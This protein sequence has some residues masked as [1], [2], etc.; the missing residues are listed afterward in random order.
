MT[1]IEDFY[2]ERFLWKSGSP[3]SIYSRS[4]EQWYKGKISSVFIDKHTHKEWF[5]VRYNSN[6]KKYIQRLCS[7]I[8]PLRTNLIN[9]VWII[10]KNQY[11]E[12]GQTLRRRNTITH[13]NNNTTAIY[14]DDTGD[15]CKSLTLCKWSLN[16]TI[17]K[18]IFS[19]SRGFGFN[20]YSIA[21]YYDELIVFGFIQSIQSLLHKYKIYIP[22]R[23]Y[24]RILLY[25]GQT[26][27]HYYS[28]GNNDFGELGIGHNN[29]VLQ[30]AHIDER[31]PEL[32]KRGII[33]IISG[34]AA[35]NI[36]WITNNCSL[37][38]HGQNLQKYANKKTDEEYDNDEK[39]L[40][41]E[42]NEER[43]SMPTECI[44]FADKKLKCISG[45]SSYFHCMVVTDDGSVWSLGKGNYGELGHG[46]NQHLFTDNFVKIKSLNKYN[47]INVSCGSYF[48]LFLSDEGDVWSCGSNKY[49]QCGLGDNIQDKHRL[50]ERIDYFIDEDI[51]VKEIQ[52]G[53]Y[54]SIALDID[55]YAYCWGR[56]NIGQ[57]ARII[58]NKKDKIINIPKL[59]KHLMEYEIIKIK[60]GCN[61]SLAITENK[62]YYMWGCNDFNECCYDANANDNANNNNN[63]YDDV[64]GILFKPN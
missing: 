56:N 35:R 8:K 58:K 48:S 50:P 2:D 1:S 46:G 31:Q 9:T 45:S 32:F 53:L 10:G 59:L 27:N 16:D 47:I 5:I 49:G 7:H 12:C 28:I 23:I 57:C 43:N 13:N 20:I 61:H 38:I 52:C 37:Y 22:N 11:N 63:K 64:N 55:G 15:Y 4:N 14:D 18:N 36:C 29:K 33:R 60:V 44:F 41:N 42:E 24:L 6:Q 26:Y 30:L 3:C 39:R 17:F 25:F 19:I 62:Q 54:H 40:E 21:T 51:I 34:C